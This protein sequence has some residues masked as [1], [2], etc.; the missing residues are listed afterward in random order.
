MTRQW[1]VLPLAVVRPAGFPL[2]LVGGLTDP[3][4][5]DLVD[6]ARA[7]RDGLDEAADAFE[8]GARVQGRPQDPAVLRAARATVRAVRRRAAL[9]E[10][11][12]LP[13]QV[14]GY[15][16]PAAFAAAWAAGCARR[17]HA[18]AALTPGY[19]AALR[20]ARD[21]LQHELRDPRVREALVLLTP[22]IL[23]TTVASLLARPPRGPAPNQNERKAVAFLQ[24]LAAKC[25]T[26][27][28]AGPIAYATLGDSSVPAG[29]AQRRGF[30]A[31][32]AVRAL[33][34]GALDRLD[35]TRLSWRSG[36]AAGLLPA[37][38]PLRRA[39]NAVLLGRVAAAPPAALR[40]LH[41]RD[42][43]WADSL[44]APAGEPDAL[45]A[46]R[47]AAEATGDPTLAG[48]AGELTVLA[49]EFATADAD[50]K[51]TA[52]GAARALL[53]R[54]GVDTA[55]RGMGELYADRVVLS[56]ED[57]EPRFAVHLDRPA[58]DRLMR[59]IGP[60]LD[61]AAAAGL[62]AWR[63]A[64][65]RFAAGWAAEFGPA[66]SVPLAEVLRTPLAAVPVSLAD[67]AAAAGFRALVERRWDGRADS[68][69][70][71]P[72]DV[73][74]VVGP[75]MLR[76]EQ[77]EGTAGGRRT[78]FGEV[79]LLLSP[80]L[81]F[82]TADR[83]AVLHGTAPVVVG[84][85]HSGLQGLGNLCCF[86]PDRAALA[87]ATR[88]WLGMS[89]A[90]DGTALDDP[91][92][93]LVHVATGNRFGKLCY[94]ELLPG[95]LELSGP[96]VPGQRRY[97]P[98]DLEVC[99]DGTVLDRATGHRVLPLL[100][101]AEAATQSPLGP[102]AC[103]LP[104]VDF[105]PFTPRI[106]VGDVV[107]QRAAWRLGPAEISP[108]PGATGAARYQHAVDL[109]RRRGVPRH[110]FAAVR[111]QRKPLYLDLA[112]PHLVDLLTAEAKDEPVRITEMLPTPDH[113]WQPGRRLCE[114]RFSVRRGGDRPTTRRNR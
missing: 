80:D 52:L 47:V 54:H 112:A 8:Q 87:A 23:S 77:R 10:Q 107:V 113:T 90:A 11:A 46:L 15:P 22:E 21:H 109:M 102:P 114:I 68:V 29:P 43:L 83:A 16:D 103:A 37:D 34:D 3:A 5:L 108:Q 66:A 97:Q 9:P 40:T 70:L 53:E 48:V 62:Q 95:T 44:L 61:L 30:V 96:S 12:H 75:A 104:R 41:R 57:H 42:V 19:A 85:I 50:G 32:W 27:A 111:G 63:R 100:G 49:G 17:D 51:T 39:V 88:A 106:V 74:L 18:R 98:G 73:D 20:T 105:G 26:N 84:E 7:T 65:E 31:F 92:P 6:A 99:R 81:H 69:H 76:D 36:P 67:T 79:P 13:E 101:D 14:P 59:R 1:R 82:A 58:V 91:I 38:A 2:G 60:V 33:L 24:R 35:P 78:T 55:R 94:L 25:E 64:R 4:L 93:E 86:L 72:A 28:F 110:C 89:G 45:H 56:E 71:D